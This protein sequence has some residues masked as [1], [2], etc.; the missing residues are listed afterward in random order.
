MALHPVPSNFTVYN[1]KLTRKKGGL[2]V[3]KENLRGVQDTLFMYFPL[4]GVGGV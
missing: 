4:S 1:D 2:Y 3:G